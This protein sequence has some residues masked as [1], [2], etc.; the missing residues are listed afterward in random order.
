MKSPSYIPSLTPLRGIAAVLVLVYHFHLLAMP[1]QDTEKY[2]FM[3]KWYLMVDLFFVLSGFIL[4]HVYGSYFKDGWNKVHFGRYIRARL[5]RIYPL[6]L[7]TLLYAIGLYF[8]ID[9]F[10]VEWAPIEKE[11]FNLAAIPTSLLLIDAWGMH[12]EATWNTPSWSI[13][14]EW[15]VYLLFPLLVIPFLRKNRKAIMVLM[16]IALTGFLL[17]MFWLGPAN[18]VVRARHLGAFDTGP[19][20]IWSIGVITG[21]AL[22][23]GLSGFIVGMVAYHAY[24]QD[25]GKRWLQN[26]FIWMGF[27]IFLLLTWNARILPDMVAVCLFGFLILST[28]YATGWIKSFLNNQ[29]MIYLGDISYSIYLVHML[30]LFTFLG[31]QKLDPVPTEQPLPEFGVRWTMAIVFLLMNLLIATATYFGIEKPARTYL[32]RRSTKSMDI[33]QEVKA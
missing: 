19:P 11:I 26:G 30:V 7:F 9:S 31:L 22:L 2:H 12:P 5:A 16:L 4:Y 8:F 32:R 10:G 33:L 1:L 13:S 17:I 3:G 18:Y 28:A 14:V 29:V 20:S 6:H 24:L 23:R 21:P 25:W 27:W 15:F